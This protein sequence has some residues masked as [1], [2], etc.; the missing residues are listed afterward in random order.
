MSDCC[1]T[2]GY[3]WIFS[4]RAA[5]AEARRYRRRGL[6]G[7]SRRIVDLVA[8]RGV[9]GRSVLEV[10][11]GIGAL[12]IDLLRA[13]ACSAVSVELIPTHETVAARLVDDMG[14]TDRVERRVL[15]FARSGHEVASADIVV[16]NRVVCCY[17]DMPALVGAAAAHTERVLVL[18]F[19][20]AR[21]WTR[22]ILATGN[23][24]LRLLRRQFRVFVHAPE[25]IL[26]TAAAG[27]LSVARSTRGV[28]WQVTLLEA[29][30]G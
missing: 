22:I 16:L 25:R 3:M 5:R 15:D 14:F 23:L 2:R 17:P 26:A 10:G 11:G 30:G 8:T 7:V 13:G 21:W 27:G 24:M 1:T 6:G 12:Q 29:A 20:N 28:F 19:P 18:S 9:E 4:E